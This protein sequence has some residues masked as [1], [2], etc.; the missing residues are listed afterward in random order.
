[1]LARQFRK[2]AGAY[3][4]CC[5]LFSL[6]SLMKRDYPCFK[7][8]SLFLIAASHIVFLVFV[9]GTGVFQMPW[10]YMLKISLWLGCSSIVACLAYYFSYPGKP[11]LTSQ[12]TKIIFALVA[13]GISLYIG[14]FVAFNVFG[15]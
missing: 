2:T 6:F 7:A 4:S 15:T 10:P 12:K 14:V 11:A 8:M 1:M 9:Y 5:A 3:K 13:T